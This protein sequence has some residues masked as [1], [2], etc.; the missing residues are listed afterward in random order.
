MIQR[1]TNK[2]REDY[3]RYGARG[4]LVYFDWLGP[5]GFEQFLKD[6]GK[7]PSKAYS[8]DRIN[9]LGNYEP[10]NVRWA[11][12][13]VQANNKSGKMFEFDG[14]RMNLYGWAEKLNYHPGAL[15]KKMSRVRLRLKH[16]FDLK[17]VF[18]PNPRGRAA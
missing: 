6:V 11:T 15:R 8:L 16:E 13:K 10:G 9:P 2:K 1:C 3:E 5:G 17:F 7:R 14:E 18:T 12:K 4:I